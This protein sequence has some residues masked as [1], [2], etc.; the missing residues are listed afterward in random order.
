MFWKR[1]KKT[2]DTDTQNTDVE[3]E[4]TEDT[5][6]SDKALHAIGDGSDGVPQPL[7]DKLAE[8]R[9]D[10]DPGYVDVEVD[11]DGNPLNEEDAEL[12]K[13]GSEDKD[14]DSSSS[15]ADDLDSDEDRKSEAEADEDANSDYEDV[16]LDPRLEE[17][18]RSMGW[19][20]DKIALVAET[21]MSILE[22][23]ATRLEKDTQHRQDDKDED[24]DGTAKEQAGLVDEEALAKLKEKLGDEGGE[25]L[26]AL[27][28]SIEGKFADKFK[29]VDEFKESEEKRRELQEMAGRASIAD[30][31][32]DS[33]AEQFP[34]IGLTKELLRND[35]GELI[36][37]P[38]LKV[39]DGLYRVATI[40]HQANGG[41]FESAVKEAIQHYAGGQAESTATR[42]VVKDLKKQ[43]KR[44]T[45]RPTQ[46]KTVRVFKSTDAKASHIIRRAKRKA[47]IPVD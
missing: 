6:S 11:D 20:S 27:M 35:K 9:G 5:E 14:V 10:Q 26:D 8:I 21:D 39:R 24:K 33:A 15:D 42:R 47:G 4:S 25:V 43:Q 18:G 19:D 17:A 12:L 29:Q 2:E 45:P 41:S 32:F 7:K 40:F 22:D 34:E 36:N 16:E 3:N 1:K 31:V 38:E 44:F 23:I 30:D 28:K 37:S 13:Q 46:R